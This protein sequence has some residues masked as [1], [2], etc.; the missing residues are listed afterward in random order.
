M[1]RSH[2]WAVTLRVLRTLNTQQG[3][4]Q[5]RELHWA[6]LQTLTVEAIH[7]ADQVFLKYDEYKVRESLHFENHACNN[8]SK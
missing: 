1:S 3:G 6:Q 8:I 7:E 4:Q 5:L 2:F